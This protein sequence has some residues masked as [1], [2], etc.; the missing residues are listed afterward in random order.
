LV[1]N[2]KIKIMK[3][4]KV[5]ITKLRRKLNSI[6]IPR[7]RYKNRPLSCPMFG[8]MNVDLQK[9]FT[10]E[11]MYKAFYLNLIGNGGVRGTIIS[12]SKA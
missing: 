3:I 10:A 5:K 6:D 2:F 11:E 1:S 9:N 4:S 12:N 7:S 8:N